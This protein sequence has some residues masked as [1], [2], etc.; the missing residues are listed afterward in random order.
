MAKVAETWRTNTFN[1]I[2]LLFF[3]VIMFNE[4]VFFLIV[5]NNISLLWQLDILV[6][7]SVECVFIGCK[8][9]MPNEHVEYEEKTSSTISM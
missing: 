1:C 5:F 9:I 7:S 2:I 3:V 8:F 6:S 4:N